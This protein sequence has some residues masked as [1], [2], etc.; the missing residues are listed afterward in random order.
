MLS[1]EPHHIHELRAWVADRLPSVPSALGG[2]PPILADSDLITILLWDTV[3]LH[4]KTIKDLHTFA[5]LH[6]HLLF[7]RVPKYRGFLAQCH[8]VTPLMYELLQ[9][10]LVTEDPIKIADSTML[11]V[12]K[13]QRANRHR[14]AKGVAAFGKNHQGWH[15][16]FKLHTS[17]TLQK[18]L[19]AVILT[20]ANIY[21]AQVSEILFNIRT[22]LGIGDSHYGASVMCKIL[23]ERS[24]T[25][26]LAPPHYTQKKKIM[27]PWQ[28][29]FL[30]KRSM[31]EAVFDILKEHLHLVSSFPR[32][33]FGYLVHY[34]RILL[35]YQ[36]L[37]L[38]QH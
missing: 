37:A 18:D 5:R 10:L 29:F 8:R 20:P 6:L 16:G 33:V 24:Q 38:S 25:F 11:E 9:Q 13:L 36:L 23:W 30:G 21:D 26:V 35:G 15:Y 22:R 34:V 31:I 12:C 32:S 14:V 7:P 4:Q 19:C 1:L 3:A 17:I 2:R 28:H 27:A